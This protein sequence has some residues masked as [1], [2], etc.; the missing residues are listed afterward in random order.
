MTAISRIIRSKADRLRA[1]EPF[2]ALDLFAGCG[3]ISLGAQLAGCEIL[4]AVEL[5]PAAAASHALNFHRQASGHPAR[6]EATDITRTDPLRFVRSLRAVSG[7]PRAEVDLLMGGPP[8]QAF[9]RVGRAKLR[10][11][12]EHPEAFLR[13]RRSGLYNH[14]L[15]FVEALAPLGVVIENVPD[16]MNYGGLNIFETIVGALKEIGYESRYGILNAVHYGVPQMRARGF[17]LAL[18]REL[19]TVP[20]LPRRT[21]EHLLPI[22]YSGTT[23]VALKSLTLFETSHYVEAAASATGLLPAITAREALSDLPR[24]T[25]HLRGKLK[26]APQRLQ[27]PIAMPA[28]A[29]QSPFSKRMRTWPGFESDGFVYDHAIRFLPRDYAI[30][31]RMRAGDQYPEA[32]TLALRMRDEALA[33]LVRKGQAVPRGSARYR[34]LTKSIVPPYDPGKFPNKWRKMAAD[35]PARTLMAHI[36][37]DTYSHIHFD[38]RQARTISVREAARLQSFPDGFRLVGTMNPAFRQIGNAVPP[39]LACAVTSHLIAEVGRA[40]GR[41]TNDQRGGRRATGG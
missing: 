25:Q 22:G 11:I 28:D 3:G 17:L 13:D 35:E 16:V 14:F 32:H 30:F 12:M 29:P 2:R 37:K 34:E 36:G 21:H 4:G 7:D 5:D 6:V 33:A 41:T 31:A 23:D 9:A 20:S 40:I 19:G 39:L 18:H 8:C 1:G 24:L 26:K 15:R 27:T 38:S 10:E